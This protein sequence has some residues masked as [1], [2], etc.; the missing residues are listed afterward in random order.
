MS[1]DGERVRVGPAESLAPGDR[2]LVSVDGN[3]VGVFNVHGDYYALSNRCPHRDGPV[4]EGKVTDALVGEWAGIGERIHE[5]MDGDPAIACPWH[6]WEFDMETG[7]H[8]GDDAFAVRTYD[9][10]VDDGVVYVSDR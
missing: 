2:E 9:V 10:E 7:V 6:G 8:L 4:C 1:D 5:T 3:E